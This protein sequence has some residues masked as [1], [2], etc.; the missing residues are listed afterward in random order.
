MVGY[1]FIR[2]D[3]VRD[4]VPDFVGEL[5]EKIWGNILE[6]ARPMD[7]SE[8]GKSVGVTKLFFNI[9]RCKVMGGL[10]YPRSRPLD[11]TS[12]IPFQ[13]TL[14]SWSKQELHHKTCNQH[15]IPLSVS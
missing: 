12:T 9:K 2:N 7:C 8:R 11:F 10:K 5:N 14:V 1:D 15:E 13:Q 3:I 4:C 6:L